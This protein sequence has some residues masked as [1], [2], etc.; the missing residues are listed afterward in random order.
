M[1]E[2]RTHCMTGC[3]RVMQKPST[4][5]FT[6]AGD[7]RISLSRTWRGIIHPSGDHMR[8]PPGTRAHRTLGGQHGPLRLCP[9]PRLPKH[10]TGCLRQR[11]SGRRPE[12]AAECCQT[13]ALGRSLA[14]ARASS[15]SVYNIRRQ[16]NP[17]STKPA[18]ET[19][20]APDPPLLL[21]SA[22][23]WK[24]W[25]FTMT[26]LHMLGHLQNELRESQCLAGASG[27]E[28]NIRLRPSSPRQHR[29]HCRPLLLVDGGVNTLRGRSLRHGDGSMRN[30]AQIADRSHA[31]IAKLLQA[32]A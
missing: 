30:N 26:Q 15:E 4:S 25:A 20:A 5:C 9:R 10:R 16:V 6:V 24:Q 8:K 28:E 21:A 31:Y 2:S 1:Q 22:Q 23:T 29:R 13:P 12:Q 14:A 7:L 11:P 19:R 17:Q 18:A 3:G 27:A 32:N